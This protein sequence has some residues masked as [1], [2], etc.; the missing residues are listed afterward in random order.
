MTDVDENVAP[1][2]T[3]GTATT[4]TV[5]ENTGSGVDIGTPVAATDANS[6]DTLTYTLGGT[7][8]ASFSINSTT[9][10][11]RTKAALDYESKTSYSVTITVSDSKLTDS[12]TVTINVTDV[13]ENVAPVFTDGTATTRTV[14]ENTG[15]GVDIGTPVSATDANTND[16]LTYTLGGTDAAS[17]SIN[18]TT[19][20][21]RT[22]AALDYES[23]T[24]YSVTI[25]VTDGNEGTDSISVTINVTDVKENR[26]PVFT[27]G[28]STTRSVVENTGSGEDIGT[29]VAATDADK[30]T[31]TYSLGGTDAASFSINSTTGQLQTK[32]ALDHETK[33]SYSVTV[34]VSDTKLT[35]NINVTIT[36][37]DGN[38]IPE[39]SSETATL[40]IA[41]NTVANTNIGSPI[42]AT[43]QDDEPITYLLG[44]SDASAFTINAKTGQIKTKASLDHETKATYTVSVIASD[45]K[46]AGS[47]TVTITVTDVNEAHSFTDGSSTTRSVAEN[48]DADTNIGT[49]IAATDPEDGALE[50]T[51]GGT[52][53]ASFAIVENTGQLKT[54]AALDYETKTSYTVTITASDDT[55]EDSITVTINVTDVKENA[56]PVFT[57]GATTS[58]SIP[59]NTPSGT[60]IGTPVAA[61]D[62]D[63]EDTLTYTLGGTDAATFDIVSSTGQLRTKNRLNYEYINTYTVTITVSDGNGG[64][65]SITVTINITN[66]RNEGTQPQQQQ[67]QQQVEQTPSNN[68]PSFTDGE[69][70]TRSIEENSAARTDIGTPVAAMDEDSSDTLSYTLS[71]A[72]GASFAIVGTS[73]QLQTKA[74]LDYETKSSYTVTVSVSDG[75]GGNDSI[76]VT[77]N[78]TNVE[79]AGVNNAP[80][81]TD[82]DSTSR[83]IAE[84]TAAGRNIGDP[85]AATDFNTT[86]TLTYTLDGTDAASFTIVGTSG[87][88]KTSAALNYEVKKTYSVMVS[89]SDGNGGTDSIAVTINVT[90]RNEAPYFEGLRNSVTFEIPEDADRIQV[91]HQLNAI[92]EDGDSLLIGLPDR[93]APQI[94]PFR[95]EFGTGLIDEIYPNL[96]PGRAYVNIYVNRGFTFDIDNRSS[97]TFRITYSDGKAVTALSITVN[98]VDAADLQPPPLTPRESNQ[99]P[100]FWDSLDIFEEIAEN[101]GPKHLIGSPI[102]VRDRD[103][104]YIVFSLGGT[105][106]DS[107]D[108]TYRGQ[109]RTKRRSEFES[110]DFE[111][112]QSYSLTV[113]I[114]DRRGGTATKNVTIN[115]SDVNEA[116]VFTEGTDT[117]RSIPE[118]SATGTNIGSTVSA[119][120][121]DARDSI[122]YSLSGT[123]AASFSI[124]STTGQLKSKA[125]LDYET[126]SSYSVKVTATDSH[127]LK[128]TITVTINVTDLNETPSNNAPVFTEGTMATRSIA[129]NTATNTNI[130]SP[131]SA[132]DIDANSTLTYTLSG[133]DSSHF[134]I[135]STTG[136][137][138]TDAALNYEDK[139]SHSVTITVTDGTQTDT[140]AVTINVTNVNEAPVFTEGTSTTRRVNENVNTGTNVGVAVAAIDPD[141][142]S[143]LTYS[144]S[145]TDATSFTI[146]SSTGRLQT[147]VALDY[148]TKSSYTVTV[149]VSDG[150]GGSDTISVQINVVNINENRAPTFV[151]GTMT[152][153]SVE[154]GTEADRNIG[155]P[156]SATDPNGD[157]LTYIIIEGPFDYEHF[158]IDSSTGQ[159]KTKSALRLSDFRRYTVQLQVTDIHGAYDRIVVDISVRMR[160]SAPYFHIGSRRRDNAS[161]SVRENRAAGYTFGELLKAFDRDRDPLTIALGGTDE[162]SFSISTSVES[163]HTAIRLET[164]ALLDYETKSTYM[165]TITATDD[166]SAS[167]SV[168]I[169]VNVTDMDP[170]T[171]MD[172]TF[173]AGDS[174]TLTVREDTGSGQNIG[175]PISATD[176]D[177]DTLKYSLS[178]T[179]AESFSIDSTSGQ[180]K[181]DAELDYETKTSYTVTVTVTDHYAGG[182]PDTITVTINVTDV[183]ENNLPMFTD[184][185]SKTL[186]I[187]EHRDDTDR[188]AWDLNNNSSIGTP[189]TATDADNDTLSYSISPSVSGFSIN[190]STGQLT[191]S[192]WLNHEAQST[193]NLTLKATDTKGDF[194]TISVTVNVTDR[195]EKPTYPSTSATAY[196][197]DGAVANSTIGE[198]LTTPKDPDENETFTFTLSG[199]D[200]ASFTLNSTTGVLQNSAQLDKD[201][202]SSYSLT[203]TANDGEYTATLNLTVEVLDPPDPAIVLRT[204]AVREAIVNAIPGVESHLDVHAVN[205]ASI[206]TLN[207]NRKSI[208]SLSSGDFNGMTGLE[209]LYLNYNTLTS[210]PSGILNETPNLEEFEVS[211][212]RLTTLNGNLFQKCKGIEAF[213]MIDNNVAHIP[214]G[215]FVGLTSLTYLQMQQDNGEFPHIRVHVVEVDDEDE[216]D[217]TAS[218]KL[219]MPTGAPTD[220]TAQVWSVWIPAISP[221]YDDLI[222]TLSISQGGTESSVASTSRDQLTLRDDYIIHLGT[223]R[224]GFTPTHTKY[225]HRIGGFTLVAGAPVEVMPALPDAAPSAEAQVPKTTKLLPNFPNPFN[226]ETW[227]PYQLN[228]PNDVSIT[229]YDIRGTV[230]R[231]LDLRQQKAGFYTDRNRAAHWDGRNM[232]GERVANGV[233]FYRLKAGDYSYLRKMLIMK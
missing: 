75:N 113:T 47:I 130:G 167:K 55:F 230:V 134:S 38:D 49:P 180:L 155:T 127:G 10:Q 33:G 4:R 28:S 142:G 1:V 94:A 52:D 211:Y 135:V 139:S 147:A 79:E 140:I 31:L 102:S 20:Q 185:D 25:T 93:N 17:F 228:K 80:V 101:V 178:G 88:L 76:R 159:L 3:D 200:A 152:S 210:L 218:F 157:T 175:S 54:K 51:L 99:A 63:T 114:S 213:Q 171:N 53:A 119:T 205:L 195:N 84:D 145:G 56:V 14:A 138:K 220:I 224:G 105:D 166:N 23:K 148:E 46:D 204:T 149:T 103:D 62:E 98:V 81:F 160:N 109:L 132:T 8:A 221:F 100:T 34:S 60:D 2:F 125:A 29:A 70:T 112:K 110:F 158:T 129:E 182:T 201:T 177:N 161:F 164:K 83:S 196:V 42:T 82:G 15:S 67:Q 116:P 74:S 118:N 141:S 39:F 144:L 26:A 40:S 225:D 151:D 48:T 59:E 179:D 58:R 165:V 11:L 122:T 108:I 168:T 64:S 174:T 227:I 131:V 189:I 66:V 43:D 226:P 90:N 188:A 36:V 136:Q 37:T 163:D 150:N 193:Y 18:S 187:A 95:F 154:E 16:T 173:T 92:D 197:T 190:A 181:T 12:I 183:V 176:S 209:N 68:A 69:S 71:G 203:I 41:E 13:D 61:T 6:D 184:G 223:K 199:T 169:T 191:T 202:Q 128:D 206:T 106:A 214:D 219:S 22:K 77:I 107:F 216:D 91:G 137:L 208:S 232:T 186:D 44:Q 222:T 27:D 115:V 21:L 104:D 32:A 89:V 35:D 9:G 156:V 24:S 87:Q 126:K 198:D 96:T 192:L 133:T 233:Y 172:P 97:Y 117:T 123:D 146:N 194:D 45:T 7:D 124:E 231:T 50:Y 121:A 5:A 215:F 57:D 72:D 65:D 207:L 120:D 153:R 78:V 212:N 162:A 143:T 73:G 217:Q 111:T 19:G 30:D 170:E 86:D 85:I 229:I